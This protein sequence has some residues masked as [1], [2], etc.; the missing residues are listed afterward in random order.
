MWTRCVADKI[1]EI[2][3]SDTIFRDLG[4]PLVS[5]AGHVSQQGP[6]VLND[7]VDNN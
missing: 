7:Y 2:Q 6:F 3:K 1:R 5:N 4:L